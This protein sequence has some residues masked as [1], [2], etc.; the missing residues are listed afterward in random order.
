MVAARSVLVYLRNSSENIMRHICIHG[1]FYQPPR[2]NPWLEEIELQDS[3]YPYH[4]WNER[5]TAECYAPNSASRILDNENRIL[6]IVNN[7]SRIS[8]NFGTLILLQSAG[9]TVPR[10]LPRHHAVDCDL[11]EKFWG[12]GSALAQAY[13]HMILPLAHRRDKFTQIRWGLRDFERR[14]GRIPE[15]MWLPETAVDLESVLNLM[16][17]MGVRFTVQDRRSTRPAASAPSAVETGKRSAAAAST[18][19]PCIASPCAA[20][21]R[22]ILSFYDGPVSQAVAFEKLLIRGEYLAGRLEAAFSDSRPWPQ[23]VHIA[24]D[25][26]TYGHHQ[27]RGDMALAYVLEFIESRE[28]RASPT[29][30][31]FSNSMRPLMRCRSSR[32]AGG[33]ASTASSA[34]AAIA[35]AAREAGRGGR[36]N[37]ARRCAPRSTGSATP[38]PPLTAMPCGD[39]AP[40]PGRRATNTS[41][42]SSTVPPSRSIASARPVST[43]SSIP[44]R[45]CGCSSYSK[46]SATRC[47]CTPA[48]AG[49]STS[50]ASKPSR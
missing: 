25:G 5:I 43:A 2:E 41:P 48:A 18:P 22:M 47:S 19:P 46:C 29:M 28:S 44:P 34:G 21:G 3:A 7:Y 8:F 30:A 17:E 31:S 12:H 4:D 38:W 24:T 35:A 16:A 50:R 49:S 39:W 45:R 40:I 9:K 33:A 13:N 11:Q 26:E 6:K 14:F 1:H 20:A 27:Y 36:R 10:N 37:G 42:S 23:F 32:T 15:G